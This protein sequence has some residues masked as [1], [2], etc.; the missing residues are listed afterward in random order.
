MLLRQEEK[1]IKEKQ[2]TKP[3]NNKHPYLGSPCNLPIMCFTHP[4][5]KGTAEAADADREEEDDDDGGEC[6]RLSKPFLCC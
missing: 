1:E 5:G 2:Q 4:L 6:D 3:E